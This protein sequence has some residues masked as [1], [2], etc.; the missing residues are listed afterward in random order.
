MSNQDDEKN[1]IC[2]NCVHLTQVNADVGECMFHM[3]LRVVKTK[4]N[5]ENFKEI[6]EHE[7]CKNR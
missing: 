1:V 3:Q 4:R 2:E 7:K 5:C 6:V